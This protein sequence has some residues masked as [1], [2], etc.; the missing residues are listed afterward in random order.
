MTLYAKLRKL[1]LCC[2][3]QLGLLAGAP[4]RPEEIEDLLRTMRQA[5]A[6]RL[7]ENVATDE[8]RTDKKS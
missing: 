4:M 6:V 2:V 7:V 1:L 8:D 5:K 3:L